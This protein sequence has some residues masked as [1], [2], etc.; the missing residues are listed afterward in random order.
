MKT[1]FLQ[2]TDVAMANFVLVEKERQAC[3]DGADMEQFVQWFLKLE[4]LW[5]R[6]TSSHVSKQLVPLKY[7]K[8]GLIYVE[9]ECVRYVYDCQKECFEP[10]QF[11][12]PKTN[13]E[14]LGLKNG[15]SEKEALNRLQMNGPNE[16]LFSMNSFWERIKEE[17]FA[18]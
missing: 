12:G 2:V 18:C 8:N 13:S 9:F 3:V 14:V 11:N 4:Q 1:L 10:F 7:S 16:I 6:Y 5:V 17:Y 15:L